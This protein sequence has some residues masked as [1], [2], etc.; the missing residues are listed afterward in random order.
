MSTCDMLP[1]LANVI[2]WLA[3]VLCAVMNFTGTILLCFIAVGMGWS[4]LYL[5][6]AIALIVDTGPVSAT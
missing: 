4:G 6:E 3:L 2:I 5:S 1:Q